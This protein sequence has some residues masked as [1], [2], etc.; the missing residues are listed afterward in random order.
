MELNLCVHQNPLSNLLRVLCSNAIFILI[1][2]LS[3]FIYYLFYFWLCW[4]FTVVFSL[5]LVA[6]RGLLF[7]VVHRLLVAVASLVTER[8]L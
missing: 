5:S 8:E 7:A 3:L 2:V 4:V 6:A 1:E